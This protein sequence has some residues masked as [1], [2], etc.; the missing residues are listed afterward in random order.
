MAAAAEK[1]AKAAGATL[2]A[3]LATSVPAGGGRRLALFQRGGPFGG[4]AVLFGHLGVV[5]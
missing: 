4:H 1:L 2:C 5:S 3:G